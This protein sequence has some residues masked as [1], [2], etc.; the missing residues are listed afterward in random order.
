MEPLNE[1]VFSGPDTRL[2]AIKQSLQ[3]DSGLEGIAISVT[4]DNLI[5]LILDHVGHEDVPINT[6]DKN[7]VEEGVLL[8]IDDKLQELADGRDVY[9]YIVRYTPPWI[10][11][12]RKS[13]SYNIPEGWIKADDVANIKDSTVRTVN[14]YCRKGNLTCER[15]AEGDYYIY[16]DLKLDYWIKTTPDYG[17]LYQRLLIIKD[18][19]DVLSEPSVA[20]M[21]EIAEGLEAR[22]NAAPKGA[23][24][25]VGFE[26]FV[27]LSL[28][29]TTPK[30]IDD[31]INKIDDLILLIKNKRDE[32]Y[33]T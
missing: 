33:R 28:G 6:W 10:R 18:A 4:F 19:I 21:F 20:M 30:N 29:K 22:S 23:K 2:D 15:Y 14:E 3:V 13:G 27:R 12:R 26:K 5:T 11:N 31:W 25:K 7:G 32:L 8:N 16:P 9:Q 17:A 24:G 1:V